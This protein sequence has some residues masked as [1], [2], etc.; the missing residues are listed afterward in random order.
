M[1]APTTC[2]VVTAVAG[3]CGKPAVTSFTSSRTGEVFAECEEHR[4]DFA[5]GPAIGPAVE[6]CKTLGIPTRTTQPFAIVA[7][8]RIVGY[9]AAITERTQLRALR[10]G[11]RIVP[12][13]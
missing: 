3:R 9:A 10:L 2:T 13:R 5:V 7:H 11:G 1:T 4:M 6:T 12:V 8:G